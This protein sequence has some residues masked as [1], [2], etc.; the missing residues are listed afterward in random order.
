MAGDQSDCSVGH[1]GDVPGV[2]TPLPPHVTVQPLLLM[3]SS[4]WWQVGMGMVAI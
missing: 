2:D 4:W 1:G 3:T